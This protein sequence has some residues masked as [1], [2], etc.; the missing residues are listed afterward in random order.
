MILFEAVNL[1]SIALFYLIHI[2]VSSFLSLVATFFLRQRYKDSKKLI[3]LLALFFN[4]AIPFVGYFF[5]VWMVY[6]LL[7]IKYSKVLKN[8]KM[9]NMQELDR[10]FPNVKR[11]FGEGSMVE[12]MSNADVPK[13]MR[14]KALS[15]V[16]ENMSRKNISLIKHSLS[17]RDDEIRLYSFSLIDNMEQD[18]NS[19][20]HQASLRFSEANQIEAKVDAAKEL[21][22]LYWDMV[23][24]DLSDDILKNF[25][26]DKSFHYAQIVFEHNMGDTGM[27]VLLGKLYLEKRAYEDASTQFIM[28]IENGVDHEYIV[29]YLAELYFEQGNYRSIRSMLNIVKSLGLNTTMYPVVEQWSL[30]G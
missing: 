6:Y 17:D 26:V 27:N 13:A 22:Y 9:L 15:V 3:F 12:L 23:Y 28:A 30:D 5:T 25:L 14:M 16:S 21:A 7:H 2:L 8:T 4:I 19:K 24:F 29:P 18:I 20:I 11:L 10:E 1:G